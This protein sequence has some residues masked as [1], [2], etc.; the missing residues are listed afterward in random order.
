MANRCHP[1][2]QAKTAF[3]MKQGFCKFKTMTFGLYNAPVTFQRLIETEVS[4]NYIITG[5]RIF[6]NHLSNIQRA[7]EKLIMAHWNPS[8]L[9]SFTV[10]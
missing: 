3:T 4:L 1:D 8:S 6:K 2:V 7:P 9:I 5:E 10:K